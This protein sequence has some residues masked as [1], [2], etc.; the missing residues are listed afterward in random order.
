[1]KRTMLWV[2]LTRWQRLGAW[3]AVVLGGAAFW[4]STQPHPPEAHGGGFLLLGG[5]GAW[6]GG[7]LLLGLELYHGRGGKRR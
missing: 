2:P 6:T 3:L 1:M 5:I 4:I 7:V